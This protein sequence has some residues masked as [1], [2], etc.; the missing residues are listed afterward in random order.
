MTT[1]DTV[2][3]PSRTRATIFAIVR[4]AVVALVV[5][6]IVA[7]FFD[8]ASRA[9][10]NPF[11]FFGYFTMQSNIITAVV[12]LLAAVATLAGRSQT[13]GLVLARACATTYI[14]VVGIVYNTLLTG[15]EGGISLEWAN[16]VLHVAF[17]VYAAVDWVF[18]GDRAP[19]PWKQLWVAL[20][21][22]AVW[23]VVILIRGATDGWVPYPFL[24]PAAGYGTVAIY[25]VAILV[26]II[27]VA[28]LVFA[29]SRMRKTRV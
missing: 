27:V 21:Y 9:V 26:V 8:T 12:L 11:N 19:L 18:F 23:L 1:T 28:A 2:T 22:P 14:V 15:L 24:D 16:W 7:T 13:P 17:P 20:I 29:V 6:A 10:I 3:R 25:C 4:L 5:T